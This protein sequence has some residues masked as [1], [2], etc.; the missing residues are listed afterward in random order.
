MKDNIKLIIFLET[1]RILLKG[2]TKNKI[3]KK[4]D[5]LVFFNKSW[6]TIN[7]KS[8]QILI[9]SNISTDEFVAINNVLK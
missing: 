2:T 9:S 3:V 1:R 5:Y 6:F 8:N 4:K 7:E